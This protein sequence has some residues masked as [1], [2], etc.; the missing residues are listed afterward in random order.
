MSEL[1]AKMDNVA[2]EIVR[3][4]SLIVC[5]HDMCGRKVFMIPIRCVAE[6]E[7]RAPYVYYL[8]SPR[9]NRKLTFVV[10]VDEDL[11]SADHQRSL[12]ECQILSSRQLRYRS[13]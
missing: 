11:M 9:V 7:A 1:Y 3:T 8:V 2:V 5:A 6:S 13:L 10:A 12:R 4:I